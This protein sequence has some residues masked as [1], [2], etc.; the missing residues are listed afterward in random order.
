MLRTV[1]LAIAA[2]FVCSTAAVACPDYNIAP[3]ASYQATGQQL[4][5]KRGFDVVAGGNH[6]IWD[7]PS[8]KST[9]T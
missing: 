1:F 5:Q 3:Q 6:Y 9:A 8:I 2:A 4:Y 7:C